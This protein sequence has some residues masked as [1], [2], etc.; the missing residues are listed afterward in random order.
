MDRPSTLNYCASKIALGRAPE[1]CPKHVSSRVPER[2]VLTTEGERRRRRD[3]G[4]Q[5]CRDAATH[6]RL[7]G[8]F[9][10][11]PYVR[12]DFFFIYQPGR[13]CYSALQGTA[14]RQTHALYWP[15]HS[16]STSRPIKGMRPSWSC[17]LQLAVVWIFRRRRGTREPMPVAIM[18]GIPTL[19]PVSLNTVGWS[20]Q[21]LIKMEEMSSSSTE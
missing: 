8:E 9:T 12:L 5:G 4:C 21:G 6:V 2:Q 10:T 17:L 7:C 19:L 3:G 16:R 18:R 1:S 14:S 11:Q 20:L 15:L 13:S